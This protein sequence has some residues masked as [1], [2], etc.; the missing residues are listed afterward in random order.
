M[1]RLSDHLSSSPVDNPDVSSHS[2]T[3]DGVGGPAGGLDA[4]RGSDVASGDHTAVDP[5]SASFVP[6]QAGPVDSAF[7]ARPPAVS[8]A[9]ATPAASP[10]RSGAS[11]APPSPSWPR[12]SGPLPLWPVSAAPDPAWSGASHLYPVASPAGPWSYPPYLPAPSP[13]RG[14]AVPILVVAIVIAFVASVGIGIGVTRSAKSAGYGSLGSVG[15]GT[16]GTR[17]DASLS[18]VLNAQSGALLDGNESGFLAA[19]SPAAT[20]AITAYKRM[21]ANLRAMQVTTFDQSVDGGSIDGPEDVDI[22]VRYC[23]VYLCGETDLTVSVDAVGGK[24]EIVAYTPA[25]SSD[26]AEPIPW[27]ASALSVATGTDVIVAA[28]AAEK[29]QLARALPMAERAA[30]AANKY[31]HW[32]EPPNYLVYLADNRDARTWFGGLLE[33]SVGEAV[34]LSDTDIEMMV[35][36]PDA[37]DERYTGAGSLAM[38]IQHE[39][40]HVA[41]LYN[42]PQASDPDTF[43]EGI[44]EYI[45]YTGHASWDDYRLADT[46]EY[47]REGKWSGQCYLT[48][49]ISS[50]DGLT[51][52]AAYGIGYLT[53]KY[54]VAKYGKSAMLDFWGGVERDGLTPQDAATIY[55]RSTWTKVNTACASYIRQTVRA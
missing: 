27:Q 4:T 37:A 54:L 2:T 46:R 12:P 31:A 34:S 22:Y 41:T 43:A 26:D 25:V 52:S 10:A 17:P 55:L 40:G 11:S 38:V 51:G 9:P 53:I 47:L 5:A 19:I 30:A 24:P 16:A 28:D 39:M 13:R 6:C 45:A 18:S 35:V 33:G 21:Y 8:A 29:S 32:G 15:V 14:P 7:V 36:L 49:E 42:D 44:A 50:S 48:K 20:A 1:R 3:G 23:L